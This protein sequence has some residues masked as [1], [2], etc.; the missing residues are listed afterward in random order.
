MDLDLP[1][2][3]WPAVVLWWLYALATTT[4]PL[5][6]VVLRILWSRRGLRGRAALVAWATLTSVPWLAAVL[7]LDVRVLTNLLSS[8]LPVAA[9]TLLL[10]W[11]DEDMTTRA[12]VTVWLGLAIVA[13]P[14][15]LFDLPRV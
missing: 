9:L 10:S 13:W 14:I 6:V 15:K 7:L 11:R 1:S 2:W 4:F 5:S 12:S 3:F 8:T